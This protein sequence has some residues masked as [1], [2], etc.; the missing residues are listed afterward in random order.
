MAFP[1]GM[2]VGL[3]SQYE[4]NTCTGFKCVSLIKS[5]LKHVSK[6]FQNVHVFRKL[7][8]RVT[9]LLAL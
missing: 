3:L 9:T 1:L 6:L 2:A 4:D 5:M 8:G 7:G